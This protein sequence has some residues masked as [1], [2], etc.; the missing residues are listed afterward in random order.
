MIV[1]VVVV[2]VVVVDGV[3]EVK[4]SQ[5][6]ITCVQVDTSGKDDERRRKRR[7]QTDCDNE[8]V[9]VLLMSVNQQIKVPG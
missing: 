7:R 2:V 6:E 1:A 4:D 3:V 9:M 5:K 8:R